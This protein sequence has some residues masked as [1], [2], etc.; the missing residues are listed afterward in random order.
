MSDQ[1]QSN[2]GDEVQRERSTALSDRAGGSGPAGGASKIAS[3]PI[4]TRK[5]TGL[6]RE[7]SIFQM[8][9]Y[10]ATSTNA[11]GLG[12][13]L[14]AL[15]LI[16]FPR[17]NPYIALIAAAVMC[18][19][20]WTAFALLTAAI[21]RVGGDYTINTRILPPWL[22]LGGNFAQ[23]V[24]ATVGSVT[25]AWEVTGFALSPALTVIGAVTH[26]STILGWGNDLAPSHHLTVFVAS[27]LALL[28][29]TV[30]SIWGTKHVVR[31]LTTSIIVASIGLVISLIVL[32]FTSQA[33]VISSV[34]HSAGHG[35]YAATVAAGLKQH[36]YPSQGG[37]SVRDT[38]G[39]IYYGILVVIWTF[40]GTYLSAEFKGAGQRR[41]QLISMNGTGI[42]Q[43]VV[44]I[45]AF[46]I[47]MKTVGYNFFV[48]ALNGNFTHVANGTVGSAGYVYF[49]ALAA[50]NAFIVT[51]IALTFLGWF[52]PAVYINISMPQRALL[53]WSFD[54][55]LPQ[56]LSAV[57][58]RTHTPVRAI[59]TV[60]VITIPL[61]YFLAY[62]ANIFNYLAIATLF[63]YI[64]I[65]LVGVAALLVRWLR[66]ELYRGSPAEWRIKGIEVLPIAGVGC[67]LTGGFA[68]FE[69]LYFAKDIGLKYVGATEIATVLVFVVPA[70][71]WFIARAIRRRQG[72]DLALAYREIPPE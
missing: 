56:R 10:N 27:V 51:I 5:A 67:A 26:N 44:L 42:F 28:L 25:I 59:V 60:F 72:V 40:W 32:A 21:P 29:M 62:T 65:A 22:A 53:A 70:I 61:A 52:L 41:R 16:L 49:S 45:I 3:L 12:L 30:L 7:V 20:V 9:A 50:R 58:E 19:F 17:A 54:G 63:G 48:S 37:Y 24:S 1:I 71:W 14:F 18:V 13:I 11:L 2:A 68:V 66:P 39:A 6:V 15:A 69:A 8:M 33:S 23:F 43:T 36:L 46:A 57:N 35:A 38:I 55:L 64:S 4:F 34:N 47:F 31:F